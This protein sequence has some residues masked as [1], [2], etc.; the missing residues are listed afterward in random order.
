MFI[1]FYCS[2]G[3]S[4]QQS[5]QHKVGHKHIDVFNFENF[6]SELLGYYWVVLV[7]IVEMD[8]GLIKT[9]FV[10]P[11]DREYVFFIFCVVI[12][13][14]F[15][16]QHFNAGLDVVISGNVNDIMEEEADCE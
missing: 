7:H 10:L 11:L 1:N 8:C 4:F 3:V 14:E 13:L 12:V 16:F 2:Q 6:W 15:L 5:E 9:F